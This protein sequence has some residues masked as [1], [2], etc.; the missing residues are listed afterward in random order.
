MKGS[1]GCSLMVSSTTTR[2]AS[3]GGAT[4]PHR[5]LLLKERQGAKE[6]LLLLKRV[7]ALQQRSGRRGCRRGGSGASATGRSQMRGR[8]AP[9]AQLCCTLPQA[10]VLSALATRHWRRGIATASACQ[11]RHG[12]LRGGGPPGA[13][14][15]QSQPRRRASCGPGLRHTHPC[16]HPNPGP[17]PAPP[18]VPRRP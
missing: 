18:C 8:G 13:D 5:L 12:S 6:R 2:S 9:P 11:A 17:S 14:P 4:P 10:S 15:P 1:E 3:C 7:F 16:R